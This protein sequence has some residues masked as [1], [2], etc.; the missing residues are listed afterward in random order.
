MYSDDRTKWPQVA[1][2]YWDSAAQTTASTIAIVWNGNQHNAH[3]LL[4]TEPPLRLAGVA[5]SKDESRVGLDPVVVSQAMF[6]ELWQPD[7][8]SLKEVVQRISGAKRCLVVGTPPPKDEAEIRE[9]LINDEY[10]VQR[11]GDMGIGVESL[12]VTANE[13]RVALWRQIQDGLARVAHQTDVEFVPV[14]PNCMTRLSLLTEGFGAPDATHA[15]GVYGVEMLRALE[16]K[17]MELS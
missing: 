1:D 14:A 7:F 13:F 2:D 9:H 16:E 8:S 11:A 4:E 10:F 12:R 3:F 5:F 17:W 15:N 6:E